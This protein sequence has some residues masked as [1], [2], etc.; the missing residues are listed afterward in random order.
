M[1]IDSGSLYFFRWC[2]LQIPNIFTVTSSCWLCVQE[3]LFFITCLTNGLF[4]KLGFFFF[5]V[6]LEKC[7]TSELESALAPIPWWGAGRGVPTALRTLISVRVCQA[8]EHCDLF[9]NHVF[10]G[11]CFH[12]CFIFALVSRISLLQALLHY[13]NY[14]VTGIQF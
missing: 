4:V 13:P 11:V 7:V 3:H 12:F 5:N 8:R 9:R 2:P 1:Y 14:S 6:W 10:W